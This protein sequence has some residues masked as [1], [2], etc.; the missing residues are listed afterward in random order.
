MA[1]AL[2]GVR[3]LNLSRVRSGPWASQTLA[4]PGAEVI[5]IERPTTGDDTR[6]WS[7]ALGH[8]TQ[9]SVCPD[10]RFAIRRA[11]F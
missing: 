9:I 11:N 8:M 6:G 1:K 5:K 10:D 7:P 4:D 3:V 2:S